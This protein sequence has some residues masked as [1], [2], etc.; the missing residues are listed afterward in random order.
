MI[1]I[2]ASF[3]SKIFSGNMV[4]NLHFVGVLTVIGI[5]PGVRFP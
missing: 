2:V 3:N 1:A 4:T 5:L